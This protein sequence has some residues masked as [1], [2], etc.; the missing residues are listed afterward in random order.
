MFDMLHIFS[1]GIFLKETQ[2]NRNHLTNVQLWIITTSQQQPPPPPTSTLRYIHTDYMPK[3]GNKLSV[4]VQTLTRLNIYKH[5]YVRVCVC[6]RTL[7]AYG[8]WQGYNTNWKF[9]QMLPGH[10]VGCH[11]FWW[12]FVCM[13]VCTFVFICTDV[14]NVQHGEMSECMSV[15]VCVAEW[16]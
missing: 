16:F 4:S 15:C 10:T 14:I 5:M 7:H 8:K 12:M 6:V 13:Y 3:T 9:I 11:T 1:I 2:N